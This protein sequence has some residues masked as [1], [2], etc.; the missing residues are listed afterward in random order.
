MTK[1]LTKRDQLQQTRIRNRV[2]HRVRRRLLI[3]SLDIR[4]PLALSAHL[5]KD[6]NTI[7]GDSVPNEMIQVG[8]QLFFAAK[9]SREG[10]ELWKSDGTPNGT[11]LVK[12]IK[13]GSDS[14][15]PLSLTNVNGTLFFA[16]ENGVNGREL[17]K[18]DGTAEGTLMVKD[19]QPGTTGS[20]PA[21]LT[22]VNGLLYFRAQT[23]A[24]GIELWKSD[25]TETGTVLV[26]DIRPNGHSYAQPLMNVGDT[27]YFRANDGVNGD[28]L[29]KSD[30]TAT[31]TVLVKDIKPGTGNSYV[32]NIM[33]VN[34]VVFFSANDGTTGYE[35]W[36]SDGTAQGTVLLKD[37][38]SGTAGSAP[39]GL[40]NINGTL[41]FNAND[42]ATGIELWKSDGTTT[43]TTLVKDIRPGTNH[44][45]ASR[46]TNLNGTLYFTANDGSTGYELWKSDGT[47][48]GTVIVK[49]IKTGVGSANPKYITLV[50]GTMYFN[51][52]GGT[53]GYEVWKSDGT[54]NGTVLLKDVFPG[55]NGSFPRGLASFNSSFVFS[56]NDGT[57]GSEIWISD[58]TS[59]G[60]SLLKDIWTGTNNAV[61]GNLVNANGTLLFSATDGVVGNEF[62]KSDGTS[63]G[64][65][66]V[67][68]IRAG[69]N[70]SYPSRLTNINGTVY[71]QAHNGTN[72]IELWRSDG[73]SE[74]TFMVRDIRTGYPGAYLANLTNLGGTLYF[75]ANDGI[76]GT[77]LWKSNGTSDGTV[78]IKNILSGAAGSN[79][80]SFEN[81]NGTLFFRSN[82]FTTGNE[83]WKSDGTSE[84]TVLVKNIMTGSVGSEPKYLTNINGTLYF[85]A[86]DGVNGYELWKS[87]GTTTGTTIVKDINSG[88]VS[89]TPK[90]FMN[91]GG[92]LYFLA[93]TST[94]GLELWK[95]DGTSTGT[96]LVK[97]I[98]PGS[99]GS[100]ASSLT[101]IGG[102]LYFQASD[103]S[104]GPELWKSDGTANGTLLVKDIL[105]GSNGS[106]PKY[107]TNVNGKLYFRAFNSTSNSDELWMSDG[108]SSGTYPVSELISNVSLTNPQN[109]LEVKGDLFCT[110]ISPNY[111][112]E[113]WRIKD[114]IRTDI[115]L[116][117]SLIQENAGENAEVGILST[118][119]SVP[120][121]SFS[122]SLVVG[123]GDS[124][125]GLFTISGNTLR[126]LNSF[127]FEVRPTYSIRIRSTD[128]LG[129]TVEKQFSINVLD[130][131][132]PP[133]DIDLSSNTVP[134]NAGANAIVGNLS[135]IDPDAANSHVY[136]LVTGTG[137]TDNASFNIDGSTLRATN[138]FDFETKSSFIVRVQSKDQ[139]GLVTEKPL[140]I[141]V[142]NI[143]ETPSNI[144]LSSSSIAENSG[145]NTAI[146]TL[147]TTDVDTPDTFTYT[148]AP[149]SGD[150]DNTAFVIDG[151][152]LRTN[153]NFDFESKSIY[154]IRIRSTDQGGLYTEKAFVISVS[155][156]NE[157]PLDISLS[158]SSIPE[159]AGVNAIVGTLSSI[160][161]DAG[162]S[163]TYTLVAGTGDSDNLSF[164]INGNSLRA[165]NNFDFETKSSYNIRIRSTDQDGLS[166]EKAFTIN[167][168][169]GPDGIILNGTVA[170]D[171]FIAT[172]TGDGTTHSWNVTRN[173][174]NVFSGTI[175]NGSLVVDGLAGSDTLQFVGL[176]TND[177]FLSSSNAIYTNG[178]LA[179]FLNIEA[180][181]ILGGIG[182]DSLTLLSEPPAG[183][184]RSFDGGLGIDTLR[185]SSNNNT[186]NITAPATGNLNSPSNLSFIATESIIGGSGND[187]FI[188]GA[189]GTL[190]GQVL[191]GDGI[192]SISFAAKSTA[193]TVNL[194]LNTATSTGG[195]GGVESF[196]GSNST[197]VL[198]VLVGANS[199]ANW[200]VSG[201][202]AGT[203][204]S[205]PTGLV[206]F[207]GFESLTGGTLE[208]QFK[209]SSTGGVSGT[210]NGS[211]AA[212]VIDRLDVSAISDPLDFRLDATTSKIL[213]LTAI[214]G[215]YTGI[216]QITGNGHGGSKISRINNVATSWQVDSVNQI[217][218]NNVTYSGVYIIVGNPGTLADTLSG[219][220]IQTTW[221]ILEAN[222]GRLTS[223]YGTIAFYGIENLT[224]G[225]AP[226]YFGFSDIGR[227]S[228]AIN[229]GAGTG[230]ID[231]LFIN[232]KPTPLDFRIDA[233]SNKVPGTI[234]G[235]YTGIEEVLGNSDNVSGSKVT[236][237]NNVATAWTV[238]AEGSILVGG[239]TY[240]AVGAIAGN[241]GTLAD[242]LTGP[243][244]ECTW[245]V[246]GSSSGSLAVAGRTV[247][248]SSV[249]NLTGGT[250]NDNFEIQ[251]TGII[252][253][254]INGGT[255]TGLN[256][257]SYSNWTT[258]VTVNLAVTTVSNAT[259]ISGLTSNFQI[260]TGGAG[261]DVLTGQAA[262]ATILIG[263]AGNDKLVGGSQRD[264]L[265]GGTGN[266]TIQGV[267]GDDLMISGT[268]AHDTNR[269]ALFS[270]YSEWTST[271]S[272]AQRTANIW[273]TGIG[274][275]NNANYFFNNHSADSVPDTVFAD[276]DL[277]DVL[278]GG[279]NQDWFFADLSEISDLTG[280]T[281][282]DRR[283]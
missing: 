248:F 152:T 271:R 177:L 136:S 78:M 171:I 29:W 17:W 30:G 215:N 41:F 82:D 97:D 233:T 118:S 245:T 56:A 242:T 146:G 2:G 86:N 88:A 39:S 221:M 40:A 45:Y 48:A 110:T 175:A 108:S 36:K 38:R 193:H 269:T 84:G 10:I 160:D 25:G 65:V 81:V 134:E 27:L 92:V 133:T 155:D 129:V 224:G 168:V 95:S 8:T 149:G 230:V 201:I 106:S 147:S 66:Q 75:S 142:T 178:A 243:A 83:L 198:D 240:K 47:T 20:Y 265:L 165:T 247:S 137:D 281:L 68:D 33:N 50:N 138:S 188:F 42:G 122:Y 34:G 254:A 204:S 277:L 208:D 70:G 21:K 102:V 169:N 258:A 172:Y 190:T 275:R 262:K 260:V 259:A 101:N 217:L 229:G 99:V 135:T 227:I 6:I 58:G 104:S 164:N 154:S 270:I 246:S 167:V 32:R 62:W 71:F 151:S 253:G 79:P 13:V 203:Y 216:E 255:G 74:G 162:N 210:L 55:Q 219:P 173:G 144:S 278:T 143:N 163:F 124:D 268:T 235:N 77:E 249:E 223:N 264:I 31:G 170:N 141:V 187:Q 241:S 11:V 197:T 96:T 274:T 131:N 237:V 257:L 120:G 59:P 236:R 14:S 279:L 191:G 158:S 69:S 161:P 180:L 186:W 218:V 244:V 125:N 212:G 89:S 252:T 273:G 267:G 111:G 250:A 28:E 194:Q 231:Q 182:D 105:P 16:A 206:T 220:G 225:V 15:Q 57:N 238:N 159:N 145:V 202:N 54:A 61:P 46:L 222:A 18:S 100:S 132:E 64:T 176:A 103:G 126:A 214:V 209:F 157:A 72:G 12:D 276:N 228:G 256:T 60:T 76:N 153:V 261:N 181:K 121:D 109:L 282:S 4:I 200:N 116:S 52:D 22:N 43:G 112:I 205:T 148:L 90:S 98:A 196:T 127:N 63:T 130:T 272:F 26:K 280:G 80:G 49:D 174:I 207:V 24:S 156:V 251:P 5:V 93:T 119:D 283:N 183:V 1:W 166:I 184:S 35:L 94:H 9:T 234:D 179:E 185:G 107:F 113:L 199:A 37:I 192:D 189:T 85:S 44:S 87:D 114:V 128:Q 3:E 73:T 213:G 19:L 232:L 117:N 211:T 263:L 123:N 140:L 150:V 53:Q 7:P 91:V 115:L 266:D 67:K 226:D 239:V 195:I 23:S 139:G 51:A